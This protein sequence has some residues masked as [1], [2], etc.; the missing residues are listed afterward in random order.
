M[1]KRTQQDSGEE[2]VT[3]KSRPM[4]SLIASAP[5]NLS[6]SASES[7][8]K[9]SYE[10]QSPWSAKAEKDD[11]TVQ[12][13]VDRDT[14]HEQGHHRFVESTHSAS[15]SELDDDKA[16]SSQEWKSYKSVDDRTEK[17]VVC[18]SLVNT[19]MLFWKKKNLMTER[20]NPLFTLNEEQGHSNSSLE[21]TK[22]NWICRWDPDLSWIGWM[23]TC[24]KR[25][26]MNVTENDEKHS[27][28]WW[29]FM[30]VT[31]QASV[32]MG[33]NYSDNWH[34]IKN[35]ED[36]TLKQMFDIS[37]NLVSEQ[38]KIYGVKTIDWEDQF[39]VVLVFDWWCTSHQSSAHK[40]PRLF[41][42]CIV[43]WLDTR[44]PS[45]KHSMGTKIGV[46]Q[47]IAGIQRFGQNWRRAN[48]IRVEYFHRIQYVAAQSRSQ[49]F[50]VETMRDT[51]E[52]YRKDNIHVD[53]PRHLLWIKRQQERMRVKRSTRLSI[54]KKI[55]SRTMVFSWS[56]FREEVVLY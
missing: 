23:I 55:W 25:S 6:S 37:A 8:V 47:N 30:S 53:V 5:S 31:L 19:S 45:I 28:I 21:T 34:S 26:S 3:A 49:K 54:C 22:R 7:P 56:W 38:D 35:R 40:G 29:M 33:K 20:D 46:V 24:G 16:W 43:S 27:V 32:F 42:F 17:P 50:T 41:R 36:L 44:E 13:V 18:L 14:S 1:A 12:P 2:R 9:R 52:F 48:G 4:M 11:R 39:M 51:R 10:S 15:Y